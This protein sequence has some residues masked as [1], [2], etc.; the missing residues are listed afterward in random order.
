MKF[1]KMF[2]KQ[3]DVKMNAEIDRY[4]LLQRMITLIQKSKKNVTNYFRKIKNFV[5]YF[6]TLIETIEYNV[7]KNMT[8]KNKKTKSISNAIKK[9][10]F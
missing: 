9:K 2:K 4:F 3:F 10:F 5:K 1:K 8:N 7:M 6:S